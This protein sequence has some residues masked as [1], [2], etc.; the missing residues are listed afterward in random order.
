MKKGY[1]KLFKATLA[2][3]VATGA[4]V[5][6]AP[7]N[8]DAKESFKDVK[9][10]VHYYEPVLNLS[11]R[12]VVKGYDDGTYRPN[13]SITRG[14]A[15][16]ILANVLGLDTVNVKDPGFKDVSKANG[17]YGAIAALAQ[18]GYIKGYD[19]KT[20]RPNDNLRRSQMAKIL[21]LGFD[22]KEEALTDTRFS[23][24]KKT[25]AYAG[26]VQALLTNN[27]TTGTTPTKFSPNGLVTRGQMATFVVRTEQAVAK[28][29]TPVTVTSTISKIN[30]DTVEMASG[31]YRIP[32]ALKA[33]LNPENQEVLK[34]ASVQFIAK[35]G[36]ISE[37]KSIDITA[38]GTVDQPL[39]L[40]GEKTVF[41]SKVKVSG[42]YITLKNIT[43]TEELTIGN[44]PAVR[45]L[46]ATANAA[47][48]VKG[49]TLGE[50][51]EVKGQ[52]IV[53]EGVS[54]LT[55]NVSIPKLVINAT[56]PV[57]IK[58]TGKVVALEIS[59][60]DAKVTL[61]PD[62]KIETLVVPKGVNAKDIIE[63]YE[64]VK[65]NIDKVEGEVT[66]PDTKPEPPTS[67]GGG[68]GSVTPPGNSILHS[69]IA[70]QVN[71][72]SSVDGINLNMSGNTLGVVIDESKNKKVNDFSNLAKGIFDVFK[73][74][75]KID[76][77]DVY[78][79][80][81]GQSV[82]LTSKTDVNTAQGFDSVLTKALDEVGASRDTNLKALTGKT[83]VIH[84]VG[85]INNN[86]Y[87]DTYTFAFSKL[88]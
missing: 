30:K 71:N 15:S 37:M 29:E 42:S 11:A 86:A 22:L 66:K 25:D 6:V 79:V 9:P 53:S 64:A 58:G 4:L 20:F 57:E 33:I 10:G 38:N 77:V 31:S 32:A 84:S 14:Q 34:G 28:E 56:S 75:A 35:D 82:L 52:V 36:L 21:T 74:N 17:Y 67:G 62:M 76:Q 51:V 63:N 54:D 72:L 8:A 24:I 60:K 69:A 16:K 19:D 47:N 85:A 55:I 59:S 39:T 87:N 5:A 23:D 2:T 83:L 12:G 18:A 3:T 7:L 88:N 27:I 80:I 26:Y 41:A 48:G 46:S 73:D 50:G 43:F 78:L 68:G 70:D 1:Q 81:N 44:T 45:A 49:V 40:N 13:A 65:G 61:S